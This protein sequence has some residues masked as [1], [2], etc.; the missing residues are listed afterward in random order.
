MKSGGNIN[1]GSRIIICV[2][3]YQ[4]FYEIALLFY[5]NMATKIVNSEYQSDSDVCA[6]QRASLWIKT[7]KPPNL[8][9]KRQRMDTQLPIYNVCL[10]GKWATLSGLEIA[11]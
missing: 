2:C 5:H 8:A 1:H 4:K 3:K 10:C 11:S 6:K 7:S 9:C